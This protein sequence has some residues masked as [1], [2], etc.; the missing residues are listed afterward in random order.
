MIIDLSYHLHLKNNEND[1]CCI[2]SVGH[3][4]SIPLVR[5]QSAAVSI[6]FSR[7]SPTSCP[8]SRVT[9][10]WQVATTLCV[11]TGISDTGMT[12]FPSL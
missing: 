9:K 11:S 3:Y 12:S 8:S 1:C 4:Y 6:A 5:D 7:G 2:S 10:E